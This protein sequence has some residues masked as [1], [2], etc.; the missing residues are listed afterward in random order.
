MVRGV[1][2]SI[3]VLALCLAAQA[4]DGKSLE[5]YWVDVEGGAATLIVTPAGE[6]I[7]IDTGMPG[8]RDPKRIVKAAREAGLKQ[9]DHL[10]TTH[11]HIDHFGG[12]ADVA[13]EI[14]IITL[15]DYGIPENNPDN[16]NDNTRWNEWIKPYREMKAGKRVL[17]KPGDSI[18][19]KQASG[20]EITLRCLAGQQKTIPGKGA[21][22][23]AD[24]DQLTEKS[25]DTSDN[26]NSL[27]FLLKYGAFEMFDGGD[28]TWNTEAKLVCPENLLTNVDI[29]DVNHHGLDT[30]NNPL[31][32]NTLAPTVAIMSNGTTKGCGAET[33]KTLKNAPSIKAIYQIH[34]NLRADLQ[35]N[36]AAENIANLEKNCEANLIKVTV[37]PG[38][39]NY[40]VS[41]PAKGHSGIFTS[42]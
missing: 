41:I 37:A 2:K 9:I 4:A 32:V 33:F 5:M 30:S 25:K 26:A 11:F 13:K 36:T 16:P 34:R 20:A 29:Y 6:S 3:L 22:A 17:V 23:G 1:L 21:G 14:P 38:G 35:N 27:V 24:C 28:L 12:A 7:L 42:R 10:I 39:E 18:P 8:E 31:L 19:L 40:T 15:Y